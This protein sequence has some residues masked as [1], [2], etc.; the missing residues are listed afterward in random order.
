[1]GSQEKTLKECV[2]PEMLEN[3]EQAL[4]ERE[5]LPGKGGLAV[6][7]LVKETDAPGPADAPRAPSFQT[8]CRF[9]E[10]KQR[11]PWGIVVDF[12]PCSQGGMTEIYAQN[13]I[14]VENIGP[15]GCSSGG[16]WYKSRICYRT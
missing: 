14:S 4:K 8:T 6:E 13:L 12:R 7:N 10:I 9:G 5:N 3:I 1:M 2:S 15:R 11:H 16:G